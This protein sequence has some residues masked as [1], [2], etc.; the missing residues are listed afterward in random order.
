MEPSTTPDSTQTTPILD[1]IR[2]AGLT[3]SQAKG[4]LALIE[5]GTL[6][7]TELGDKTGESRTNAYMICEKLEKLGLAIKNDAKKSTYAATSPDNLKKLLLTQQRRL[8]QASEEIHA[9]IPSL[10]T[11]FHLKSDNAGI[12]T[13]EGIDGIKTLYDDIIRQ[14]HHLS[15]I[16]STH[17]RLDPEIDTMINQQIARQIEHGLESRAL[18]RVSPDEITRLRAEDIHVQNVDFDAPA[19]III[20]GQT[21]A[22]ST[23]RHGMITSAINHPDIAETFQQMFDALW[24]KSTPNTH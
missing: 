3:E 13:L 6:T 2:K 21:V 17:D 1:I 9:I 19:Q 11:Q 16:A 15:I 8:K 5:H 23:F 20:Y 7:P 4:Y 22:I 10:S 12:I 14:G 24:S 18:Y